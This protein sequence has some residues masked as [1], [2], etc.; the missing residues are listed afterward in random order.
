[1]VEIVIEKARELA[2]KDLMELC[3]ACTAAIADG[4]GFNWVSDPGREVLENYFK[5]VM[6]VP[7]RELLIGKLDGTVAGAIQVIKPGKSKETSSFQVAIEGHFVAPWARGHGLAKALLNEAEQEARK[8][9]FT[10]M[11]LSVRETQE[12]AIKVYEDDGFVRW[13]TFPH[14]EIVGGSM[15]AG[16]FFYKKLDPLTELV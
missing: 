11:K 14:Y 8:N 13:G 2:G 4:L 15:I 12:R 3:E 6:I 9:G 7:E 10:V 16:H 5:G 1:M